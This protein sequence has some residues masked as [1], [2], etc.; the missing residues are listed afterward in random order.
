MANVR[1]AVRVRPLSRSEVDTGARNIVSTNGN[2]ISITNVK[3]E[4]VPEY[5]DSRD[6]VKHF[7]FDYCYD[8]ALDRSTQADYASQELV[9]QDLGTEVL[10]AAFDGYNAC[11][12]AY[13]QTGAGKTYTMMGYPG[14][15]GLTPRICE[16]FFSHVDINDA[17]EDNVTFRVEISYM[18]IYNERVRDL[19]RTSS[20]QDR[21][22][23][24]VR[25]HPKDGPY[26]QDLSR[27][28]VKD[29]DEVQ[30]L[31]DKGNQLR[32]TAA[33]HM[34]EHS[35]RSHAI[36]TVNFTQARLE[37]NMPS[38][39]VSKVHLVD[40]AGS[41][42]ADPSYHADYKGRITEGASINKSLNTL[43]NVIKALGK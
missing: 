39:T 3:L 41:E 5:G 26:V 27:H 37:D 15:I 29:Y 35:S 1:V 6:R 12:L 38:E 18:E 42:R 4:G 32:T 16:G 13:G 24:K 23:L 21:F 7:T 34:H 10:Q 22:K 17:P 11:L 43:G 8:S 14:E 20:H 25:E 40:L 19:L 28:V 31:L 9:Y 2:C 36:V 33:T 30:T